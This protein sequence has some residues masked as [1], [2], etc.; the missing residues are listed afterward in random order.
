M[1]L[2]ELTQILFAQV[3]APAVAADDLEFSFWKIMFHGGAFAKIVMV[4]VLLLGVFPC[5]FSLSVFLY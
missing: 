5:I 4:T 2:T 3:A 1:L